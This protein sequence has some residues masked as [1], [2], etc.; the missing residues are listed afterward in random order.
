MKFNLQPILW[1]DT[2]AFRVCVYILI[3]LRE[4]IQNNHIVTNGNHPCCMFGVK[5]LL[6]S[7]SL[8]G[9]CYII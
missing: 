7:Q 4:E 6:S 2:V 5:D 3:P 9:L 8:R 1:V